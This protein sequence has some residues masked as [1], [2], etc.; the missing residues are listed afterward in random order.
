MDSKEGHG[1]RPIRERRFEDRKG[2]LHQRP[3]G[4]KEEHCAHSPRWP[5]GNMGLPSAFWTVLPPIFSLPPFPIPLY[6]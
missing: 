2:R 6:R 4:K 3:K 5:Y 1:T